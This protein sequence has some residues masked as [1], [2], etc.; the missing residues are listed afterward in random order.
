MLEY[1]EIESI[2]FC[3]I[4]E[5]YD[6]TMSDNPSFV[7]NEIIVHNCGMRKLLTEIASVGTLT[8]DDLVAVV[9]LFRPGPLDAGLCD[10]YV[11]IKQGTRLPYYE[12]PNMKAALEPT[13]GVIIFQEQVMQICRDVAGFT[14]AQ[15]DHVRKAMGKKDIVKMKEQR[16]QFCAGAFTVSGMDEFQSGALWDKIEV[17]AGYAFN[18]SHSCE[19][20]LISYWSMYI[21]TTYPAEFFAASLTVQDK[22]EKLAPLVIDAQGLGIKIFPPDLNISSNKIEIK[23]ENE[24]YAPFQA[25]KGV[26]ENT[27]DALVELRKHIGGSYTDAVQ[28]ARQ[29]ELWPRV[30]INSSVIDKLE[31]IGAMVSFKGGVPS[32]HVDRLKDRLELMPGFTVEAVKATRTI[33]I[34]LVQIELEHELGKMHTCEACSLKGGIHVKPRVAKN[35]DIKFMVVFDSPSRAEEQAQK[36]LE[37]DGA[38]ALKAAMKDAG[39]SPSDGYYTSL[40]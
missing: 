34:N 40:V 19:Y 30:K 28:F 3:G 37:G 20:A 24:L 22:D 16:G 27:S 6:I 5:T 10:E 17:F 11:Q 8:F 14:M 15:A 7:A 23:G 21:K 31:R 2:D 13:F 18:K 35:P 29:K 25:I 12:H 33:K 1:V 32:G 26:S 39:I 4:D 36:M 9:A 38:E